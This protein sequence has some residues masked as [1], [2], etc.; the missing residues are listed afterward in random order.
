MK[1]F[2]T[3]L[4]IREMQIIATPPRMDV[5]ESYKSVCW[6]GYKEIGS[7]AGGIVQ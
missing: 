1:R 3:S 7:Q 6:Q 5:L 4:V 2:S